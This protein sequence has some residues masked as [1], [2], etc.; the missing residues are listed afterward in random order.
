MLEYPRAIFLF[1]DMLNRNLK[2]KAECFCNNLQ[3][4]IYKFFNLARFT[5]FYK[6]W[7]I[8]KNRVISN[9][10]PFSVFYFLGL[11]T[12]KKRQRLIKS[13]PNT[14]IKIINTN[15]LWY[16]LDITYESHS[17]LINF[18]TKLSTF[19]DIR[20]ELFIFLK[21]FEIKKD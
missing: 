15:I 13:I 16:K 11:G 10:A 18:S 3:R 21:A 5:K 17:K 19:S 20:N 12:S 7:K 6:N 2:L 9:S 4:F 1:V 14:S 8:S